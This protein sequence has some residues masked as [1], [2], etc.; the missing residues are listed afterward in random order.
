MQFK[1]VMKGLTIMQQGIS[2]FHSTQPPTVIGKDENFVATSSSNIQCILAAFN[3][4]TFVVTLWCYIL[5]Y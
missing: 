2:S 3:D 1:D 5:V 4:G